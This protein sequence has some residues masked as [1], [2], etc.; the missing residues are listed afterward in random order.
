[1]NFRWGCAS[2]VF[3][4]QEFWNTI[5]ESKK[6]ISHFGGF[7]LEINRFDLVDLMIVNSREKLHL[8]S[9]GSSCDYFITLYIVD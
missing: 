6:V 3:F 4:K 9:F 7:H 1:M 5:L 2:G 8:K